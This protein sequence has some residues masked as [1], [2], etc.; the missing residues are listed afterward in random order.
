MPLLFMDSHFY[1]RPTSRPEDLGQAM[2]QWLGEVRE[3][4]GE[5]SLLWHQR[6]LSPD[7]GWGEGFRL[8]LKMLSSA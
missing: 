7:Y 5:V 8:L 1:D 6:V 3:V 4:G 2:A